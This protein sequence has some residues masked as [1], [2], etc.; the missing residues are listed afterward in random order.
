MTEMMNVLE[1]WCACLMMDQAV[2]MVELVMNYQTFVSMFS[3]CLT[4]DEKTAN[5]FL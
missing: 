4:L 3:S 2:L 5:M 1:V